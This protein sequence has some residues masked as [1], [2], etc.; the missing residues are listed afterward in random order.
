MPTNVYITNFLS[1]SLSAQTQISPALS[2]DYWSN[3]TNAAN[4]PNGGGQTELYWIDRVLGITDNKTWIVSSSITVCNTTVEL[5]I[6]LEG[7]L[8]SSD[9]AVQI[10]AGNTKTGWQSENPNLSFM[11][12][13]NRAYNLTATFDSSIND[14]SG[15]FDN[16]IFSV[17]P[18]IMPQIEHVV[19]LMMENRSLDNLL[20]WIYQP[21]SEPAQVLPQGSSPSYN[22]LNT[23]L[24]NSDINF[25]NREPVKVSKGTTD[26]NE[27]DKTISEWCVPNPDPGEEFAHV[28][29]QISKLLGNPMGGFLKDYTTQQSGPSAAQI[30]QSYSEDQLPILSTLAKSFAV[31]DSWHASVPSQTWPNRAFLLAGSS[32][33]HVNNDDY[34]PYEIKTIFDV[35]TKNNL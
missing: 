4:L 9:I 16:V 34:I 18:K 11:A 14:F 7:T 1:E 17:S 20:G 31:S 25:N 3:P 21:G 30:M 8:V 27:S 33:G 23:S 29:I 32:D 13:D 6:R 10:I 28:N 5:Q 35:F 19:V 15:V 2:D 22:G 12:A 26:W 24:F